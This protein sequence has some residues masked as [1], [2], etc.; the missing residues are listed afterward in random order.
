MLA[1]GC[2]DR[3]GD[4]E[5]LRR[6]STSAGCGRTP[7]AMG[8]DRQVEATID[9][10]GGVR[11]YLV[12]VPPEYSP[13]DSVPVVFMFHGA[14]SNKE[15][16]LEYSGFGPVAAEGGALLVLP[17]ALGQPAQRWSPFGPGGGGVVGVDD[18]AFFDELLRQVSRDFC[19]D[20]GRVMAAGLSSGGFMAA[21]VGCQR[22]HRVTAVGAV[23]G[24]VWIDS[25]CGAASPTAYVYFHGTEDA[26]VP[27][28]GGEGPAGPSPGP[29]RVTAG[30]WAEQ[31]GCVGD[32]SEE[33]IGTEVVHRS[34]SDCD[35]PTDLYIVEGGGHTWPGA[36]LEGDVVGHT[37]QDI[38]AS[39]LIWEAFEA[40]W[41]DDELGEGS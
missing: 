27:F 28:D 10:S 18:L 15:E 21:S 25:L 30:S 26:I 31:N 11:E 12:V 3:A 41:P 1:A 5:R 35:A 37:T 32:P 36:E 33:R 38:D 4:D 8:A 13:D 2:A 23:A 24:T 40:S 16:Q 17:D 39:E 14:G 22:S 20:P 9:S 29:V 34:W 7:P 19:V 6:L